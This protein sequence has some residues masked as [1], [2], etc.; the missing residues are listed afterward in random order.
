MSR[1]EGKKHKQIAKELN[2]SEKT[3]NNH[4]TKALKDLNRHLS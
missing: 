3:V 1:E 4:L 2:I